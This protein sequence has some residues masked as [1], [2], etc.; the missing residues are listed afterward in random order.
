MKLSDQLS[1]FLLVNGSASSD[2]VDYSLL[3]SIQ[4]PDAVYVLMLLS[5]MSPT[6]SSPLSYT[7]G[8]LNSLLTS[9]HGHLP[10][11]SNMVCLNPPPTPNHSLTIDSIHVYG[12]SVHPVARPR[13]LKVTLNFH[14]SFHCPTMMVLC[15]EYIWCAVF[16]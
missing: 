14:V 2:A 5:L 12:I 10:G 7:C 1:E 3:K 4:L 15:P 6:L 9:S 8:N 16:L 11:I 13:I